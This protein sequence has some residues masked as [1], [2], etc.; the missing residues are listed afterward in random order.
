M[1]IASLELELQ[2]SEVPVLCITVHLDV[3][4]KLVFFFLILCVPFQPVSLE[5]APSSLLY[6]QAGTKKVEYTS[7]LQTPTPTFITLTTKIYEVYGKHVGVLLGV[8]IFGGISFAWARRAL[9]G[10]KTR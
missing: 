9:R 4:Y 3:N 10:M 6:R 5:N 7:S 1:T 2:Q 8:I